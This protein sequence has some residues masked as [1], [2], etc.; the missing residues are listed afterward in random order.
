MVAAGNCEG[1]GEE[2]EIPGV[3]KRSGDAAPGVESVGL[4]TGGRRPGV[5]GRLQGR[6][7]E[8]PPPDQREISFLAWN[9]QFE[10]LCSAVRIIRRHLS[11]E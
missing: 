3:S 5:I 8:D 6:T 9:C 1:E 7:G 11:N 2:G 4:P 10:A